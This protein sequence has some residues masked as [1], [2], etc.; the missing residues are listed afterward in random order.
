MCRQPLPLFSKHGTNIFLLIHLII[1]SWMI[2]LTSNTAPINCLEKYLDCLHFL[3]YLSP[4]LDCWDCRRITF[5]SAQR[6]LAYVRYWALLHRIF[7]T[8]CQKIFCCLC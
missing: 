1:F 7:C 3:L 4:V 5:Y 6:K 8:C 2:F